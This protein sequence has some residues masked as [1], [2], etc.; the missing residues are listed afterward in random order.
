MPDNEVFFSDQT[1]QSATKAHIVSSYFTAW[2]R[3]IKKWDCKMAY[4]DL[5]CGPG[6]YDDNKPS[7]PL[8]IIQSTLSDPVL[9]RKMMFLFNDHDPMNIDSLH[10]EISTL[11]T[12]RKLKYV[13]YYTQEIDIDS[14]SKLVVPT[15]VPVLSFVDPFG[16]KGLTREL[17]NKLIANNGSDCIF[18]F[19]YN[20]INMALSSNTKFD[21]H[22]IGIFGETRTRALKTQ[23]MALTPSQ[24]EPVVI[25]A[26]VEALLEEKGNYVLPFKFYSA[27]MLRT[28]HFIVFVT[29]HP[30]A[31]KIMKQIMYSNSARDSDGVASFSFE[32]SR[33]FSKGNSQ[34]SLFD[35]PIKDLERDMI[36]KH[37]GQT[38]TVQ[39]LCDEYDCDFTNHF[40]SQN[41]T[42]VLKRMELADQISVIDGRKIKMRGGKPTM[43]KTA[44]IRFNE[45]K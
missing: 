21:E 28:S 9:A 45:V 35:G 44:T 13:S 1:E 39:E 20:R 12:G 8:Q 30:T 7:A 3:V 27:E 24:R 14:H 31:C 17:I 41:V 5:F 43:P 2:S 6:R 22:L 37:H 18:F 32:D 19:N 36:S 33:N 4:I 42:D 40:V 29:K 16:Y 11:D 34:L 26:L 38:V 15:N 23:L 10:R 25:N